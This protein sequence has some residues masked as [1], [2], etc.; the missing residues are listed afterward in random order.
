MGTTIPII[1]K[2]LGF[3]LH[4]WQREYLKTGI[5]SKFGRVSGRTTAYCI[6]LALTYQGGPIRIKDIN[7]LRDEEHGGI[8]PRWFNRFFLKIW[9]CLKDAG[10]PVVE[11]RN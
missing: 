5:Y 2:A 10:L 7:N 6:K 3:E 1:E 11:V 8:Y 4:Q 9:E